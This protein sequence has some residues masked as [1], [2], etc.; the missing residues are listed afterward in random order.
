[1]TMSKIIIIGSPG[2]G[3][4]T[5]SRALA[6]CT[7]LPL[8]HLDAVYWK[9]GWMPTPKEQF[10]EILGA[11]VGGSEW[12]IEGNYGSTL[13]IRLREADTVIWLQLPRPLCV[14]RVWKRMWSHRSRS[15]SDLAEGCAEG[16]TRGFLKLV[17]F[18]WRFP[19]QGA[20]RIQEVL[21][22]GSAGKRVIILRSDR[23]TA[24]FLR[25]GI[26]EDQA[27]KGGA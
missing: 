20:K 27:Y 25:H 11:L 12:I 17:L 7:G 6:S 24:D 19:D 3:K 10:K 1:M 18:A 14:W 23:E 5:F 8:I 16:F 22:A 21:D 2:S 15:R 13:E 9:P 26:Q 4:S